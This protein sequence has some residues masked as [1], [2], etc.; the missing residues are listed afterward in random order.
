MLKPE[1]SVDLAN[2][3]EWLRRYSKENPP[4]YAYLLHKLVRPGSE[5]S[6]PAENISLGSCDQIFAR[7][8]EFGLPG[9]SAI[10]SIDWLIIVNRLQ[11]ARWIGLSTFKIVLGNMIQVLSLSNRRTKE[12]SNQRTITFP[13]LAKKPSDNSTPT[14]SSPTSRKVLATFCSC[15]R[16]T[17]KP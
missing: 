4:V 12:A 6:V 13:H 11:I 15:L 9:E 16:H 17:K 10:F 8:G 14:R 5:L 7:R 1:W 2:G 3:Y